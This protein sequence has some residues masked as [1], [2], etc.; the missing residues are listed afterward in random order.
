M[1]DLRLRI[2]IKNLSTHRRRR[3]LRPAGVIDILK[4]EGTSVFPPNATNFEVQSALGSVRRYDAV[5][6]IP[7]QP[8][9]IFEFKSYGSVPPTN[10]DTQFINDLNNP[11]ITDLSQL[12]WFFDA[13]KNPAN[14]ETGM[15]AAIDG[16]Q[17]PLATAQ[18]FGF[19]NIPDFKSN[20]KSNFNLIFSLK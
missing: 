20:L 6:S 9:K 8:K 14:F 19:G 12:K 18:K 15:K 13:A 3:S 4:K 7:G 1:I 5:V 2:Q 16:L 11:E 17:I 10:F